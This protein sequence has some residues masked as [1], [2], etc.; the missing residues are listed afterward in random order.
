[1]SQ[2]YYVTTHQGR[3][4]RVLMGWDR[5]LQ[6][7][8]M[9]IANMDATA[10]EPEFLYSNLDDTDLPKAQPDNLD[11]F[12]ERLRT[13]GIELPHSMISI[14]FLDGEFNT[15][16][17]SIDH[18]TAV[19]IGSGFKAVKRLTDGGSWLPNTSG[20]MDLTVRD[21][22]GNSILSVHTP[23]RGWDADSL[24]AALAAPTVKSYVD[25]GGTAHAYLGMQWLAST[26]LS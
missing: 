7:Y 12:L 17:R 20:H 13:F 11:P 15:G 26:S 18:T 9:V 24:R 19:D 10:D 2:H 8:F 23:D 3:P 4:V 14:A 16:N 22:D 6:G 25:D 5:P 21:E 1:M